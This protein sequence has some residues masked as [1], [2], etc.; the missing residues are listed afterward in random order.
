[1]EPPLRVMRW[2]LL[3]DPAE[4]GVSEGGVADDVVPA[5]DG[6]LGGEDGSA[7]GVADSEDR[8]EARFGTRDVMTDQMTSGSSSAN[9]AVRDLPS[10]GRA[11]SG[12]P[13]SSQCSR[14]TSPAATCSCPRPDRHMVISRNGGQGLT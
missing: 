2:P 12:C 13:A 6:E 5:L 14:W 9:V 4:D 11:S 10:P 3:R 1:M 7:A 8:F